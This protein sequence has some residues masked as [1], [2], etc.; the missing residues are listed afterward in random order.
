MLGG[1]LSARARSVPPALAKALQL[2]AG[3]IIQFA[4]TIG[5]PKSQDCGNGVYSWS[6]L[7]L[8]QINAEATSRFLNLKAVFARFKD[9]VL[10]QKNP[11]MNGRRLP[12]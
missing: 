9:W 10:C 11:K 6:Q 8:I 7:H 12:R 4:Q 1:H 3:Q 2:P 5:Y